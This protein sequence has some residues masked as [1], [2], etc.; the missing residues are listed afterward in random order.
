MK[1]EELKTENV[2]PTFIVLLLLL[3]M[4]ALLLPL[5]THILYA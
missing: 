1:N 2:P 3:K 5:R 4:M